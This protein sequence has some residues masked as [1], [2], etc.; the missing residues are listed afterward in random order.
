MSDK[1]APEIR[2]AVVNGVSLAYHDWPGERGPLL[3]IPHITGH[4]GTFAAFA[5]SLRSKYRVLS[6]DLRG[7]CDSDKPAEGY[8]FAYHA[9]DI[10]AFA[11]ALGIKEFS[12]VG[13]SFGATTSVY[14]ASLQPGR[15]KSLILM[16]G[17]ADPKAETLRSMYPT[18][19]RLN[20]VW[21]SM[22]EYIE[23]QRSVPWNK[24]WTMAL[25]NCLREE[26]EVLDNGSVRS[27]S[28]A[29]AI[30]RD[31]DM[32]FWEN[33]WFHLSSIHCPALFLR[34]SQGLAGES[35]HVY[36]V[37]EAMNL[38]KQIRNC[39]YEKVDGGNHYTF[40]MQDNPPVVPYIE[41]FLKD[42]LA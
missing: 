8:G 26:M 30:E 7:R 14:T 42:V 10:I 21:G 41:K 3:C 1:A 28:S 23:K 37:V 20:K 24:P 25:E 12:L 2:R 27:K 38:V 13:H 36:S 15:V 17:G 22:D 40:L 33:V 34:P 19:Q 5:A 35:G 6:L 32:H 9:R 39:R 4:K 11:D 29:A 31:L 18:I 16:D